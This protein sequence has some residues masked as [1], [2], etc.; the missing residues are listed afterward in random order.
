MLEVSYFTEFR[1]VLTWAKDSSE[2]YFTSTSS[3]LFNCCRQGK[4]SDSTTLQEERSVH[5]T[6]DYIRYIESDLSKNT[7]TLGVFSLVPRPLPDFIS[8]LWK[9]IRRRPGIKTTSQ[10]GNGGLS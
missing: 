3:S 10:T 8:Q 9:K 2:K 7:G 1:C 5:A 6:E 4:I